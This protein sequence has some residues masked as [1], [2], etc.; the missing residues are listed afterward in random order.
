MKNT[1]PQ[2]NWRN[3]LYHSLRDKGLVNSMKSQLRT[4]LVSELKKSVNGKLSIEDLEVPDSGSLIHRASN[5]L[6]ADHLRSCKYDY[7]YSVF[8]PECGID[9]AKILSNED[10]LQLLKISPQ[11]RLYKKMTSAH[12]GQSRKG[13]LWQLLSELCYLHSQASNTA[14]TQTDLIKVATV[15]TLDEK[16]SV[17]D[18]LFSSRRE[19]QYRTGATALEDRLLKFQRH[20]EERCRNEMKLEVARVKEDEVARI[21]LEEKENFRRELEKARKDLERSYQ[22]KFD[23]LVVRERNA[24]ERLQREQEMQEKEV[25]NQ[26]QSILE[27]IEA[28]RQREASIK[29]ESEVFS[30]E[31]K[32]NSDRLKA[33]ENEI[34]TRE[35]EL[36]RK[37]I[38]FAQRL[39]NEMT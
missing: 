19:E 3:R 31:K 1:C 22:A 26:R 14:S 24:A 7:T 39:E 21:R 33:Q 30:R 37:E 35:H 25:Y 38:E 13:F 10:V 23:A 4:S 18:E 9:K 11:S 12:P 29:R 15:S 32:L 8:L 20:L 36:S 34:R 27:E 17:L 28:V 16:M 6:V 2:R 5:S